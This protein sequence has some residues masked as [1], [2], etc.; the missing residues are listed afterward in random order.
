MSHFKYCSSSSNYVYFKCVYR[1]NNCPG[2]I[3]QNIITKEINITTHCDN[4]INHKSITLNEFRKFYDKKQ[5]NSIPM[6][7]KRLQ[8]YYVKLYIEA[9][10]AEINITDLKKKFKEETIKELVL[11]NYIIGRIKCS[12]NPFDLSFSGALALKYKFIK[13]MTPSHFDDKGFI[14]H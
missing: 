8:K 3:R 6:E 9:N 12:I 7:S 2:T 1:R 4:K 5:Y 11:D 14:G 13:F 10:K